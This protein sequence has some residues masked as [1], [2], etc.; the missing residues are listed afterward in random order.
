MVRAGGW[1]CAEMLEILMFGSGTMVLFFPTQ[2]S[3]Q[4]QNLTITETTKTVAS[5]VMILDFGTI[6]LAIAE[7]MWH[8]KQVVFSSE[9]SCS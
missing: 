3:G 6:S 1:L 5:S 2:T 8:A 4:Q 9:P 7:L